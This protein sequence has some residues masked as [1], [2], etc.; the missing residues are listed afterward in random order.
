[1]D[2]DGDDGFHHIL[3]GFHVEHVEVELHLVRQQVGHSIEQA[4][5]IQ[6]RDFQLGEEGDFALGLPFGF[7]DVVAETRRQLDGLGTVAPM[8]LQRLAG[9]VESD[10]VVARDGVAA[11]G[12]I[13]VELAR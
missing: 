10:D 11:G 2:I 8:D 1:M 13:E 5:R 6:C 12:D 7:H 4:F 9:E 3:L